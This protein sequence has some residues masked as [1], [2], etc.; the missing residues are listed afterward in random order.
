MKIYNFVI[1][2]D[3]E[4]SLSEVRFWYKD[5]LLSI[6]KVKNNDHNLIQF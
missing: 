5:E 1:T 4:F 3:K 2:P 6:Q